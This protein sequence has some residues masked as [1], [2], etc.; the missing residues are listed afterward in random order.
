MIYSQTDGLKYIMEEKEIE[1]LPDQFPSNVPNGA[2]SFSKIFSDIETLMNKNIHVNVTLG[3]AGAGNGILNDHGAGHI[4]MVEERAYRI[5][6]ERA[7]QLSGYEIFILLLSIHFHDVGNV[8]G[9]EAHEEKIEEI[10]ITLKDQIPLDYP[11]KRLIRDIAMAH[12]GKV[13]GDKDTISRVQELVHVDGLPIRAAVL[14]SILRY[15]DEIADDKNRASTFLLEVGGVPPANKVFHEYSKALEP[16]VIIEDTLQL[17]YSI[18]H[19]QATEKTTKNSEEVY[20]Y[21]EI[22]LRIQKC[23]CELEY[24]RKYSQGFIHISCIT[25]N[26]CVCS[27]SGMRELYSDSFKLRLSGYPNMEDY[28]PMKRCTTCI[29]AGNGEHLVKIVNGG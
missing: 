19:K 17:Q 6:G 8:L 13:D 24:C 4:A 15:A 25:V 11:V 14:A 16:A 10:F 3:A 7:K 26:I 28:F 18:S 9:R 27:D 20:L 29:K 2:D 22:L 12:G 23:L 5:L 21:D 1:R